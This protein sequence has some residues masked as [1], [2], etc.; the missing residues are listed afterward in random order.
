MPSTIQ[1]D[2]VLTALRRL[3]HATNLELHEAIA[4]QLPQ[5][6]LTSLHRITARMV[7]RGEIR[8][9]P[10]D[11]RQVVLDARP[12]AHDH[13]VCT[14]CGGILDITLPDS[15]IAMIQEQLGR[16]LVRDGIVVRGRCERCG[17][18][19]AGNTAPLQ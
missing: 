1:T 14:V 7:E 8:L 17:P 15:T 4:D 10:S 12:E 16:N 5:L 19:G 3:G 2:T 18:L 11:G 9:A 6:G 13:F